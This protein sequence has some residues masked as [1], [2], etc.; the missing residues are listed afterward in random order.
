MEK[1]E[2]KHL[3]PYLPY[4]LKFR[5]SK[6]QY[7]YGEYATILMN[8][9]SISEDGSSHIE[10][11]VDNELIFSNNLNTVK[12]ILRPL[13]DLTNDHIEDLYFKFERSETNASSWESELRMLRKY[14]GTNYSL[15]LSWWNYLYEMHYDIHGLI[16][17]GLAIDINTLND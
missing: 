7:K 12:P 17:K 4:G 14:K 15:P 9:L 3:A 13:S 11:I 8:G 6:H 5:T 16:D 1:L 10:F 2:L